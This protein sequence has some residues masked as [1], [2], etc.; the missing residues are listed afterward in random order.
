MRAAVPGTLSVNSLRAAAG[1]GAIM[2]SFGRFL[3]PVL[4]VLPPPG[5][6]EEE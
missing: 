3:H 6:A 2:S 1:A 5:S 4:V